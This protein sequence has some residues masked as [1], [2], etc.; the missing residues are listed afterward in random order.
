MGVCRGSVMWVC[1][2]GSVMWVCVGECDVGGC[3]GMW[4]CVDGV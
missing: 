4:V 2:G 1:V 3:S